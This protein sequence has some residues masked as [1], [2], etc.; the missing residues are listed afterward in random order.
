MSYRQFQKILPLGRVT[1][2]QCVCV[3][4]A[5]I[6]RVDIDIGWTKVDGLWRKFKN[7]VFES[8]IVGIIVGD[9]GRG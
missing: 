2:T 4:W 8:S 3:S 6:F 9:G 5:K 1:A 7:K